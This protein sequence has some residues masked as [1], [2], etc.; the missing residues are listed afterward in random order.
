MCAAARPLNPQNKKQEGRQTIQTK[1]KQEETKGVAFCASTRTGGSHTAIP[2]PRCVVPI[3]S[4]GL[5]AAQSRGASI[6]IP[7]RRTERSRPYTA[8]TNTSRDTPSVSYHIR[9]M[10]SFSFV[11]A[12]LG[13]GSGF[14]LLIDRQ[15]S[16]STPQRRRRDQH[17][18]KQHSTQGQN[19]HASGC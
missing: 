5:G 7:P 12:L 10:L 11:F 9:C 17:K 3:G 14:R 18:N 8:H 6:F 2:P 19:K 4:R 15:W 16:A 1:G 13:V